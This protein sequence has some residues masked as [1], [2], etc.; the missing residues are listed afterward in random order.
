MRSDGFARLRELTPSGR[1][2]RWLEERCRQLVDT[3]KTPFLAFEVDGSVIDWNEEA[4]RLFGWPREAMA[5]RS[6][7]NTVLPPPFSPADL[8]DIRPP[9]GA[10]DATVRGRRREA[11]A[12]DRQ[13]RLFPVELHVWATRFGV[14][15]TYNAFVH[16]VVPP[17][18]PGKSS[19][20]MGA[21]IESSGEAII[22]TELDGT[23]RTWNHAAEDMFGLS[24]PEAVGQPIVVVVPP[25]SHDAVFCLLAAARD[26]GVV[27]HETSWVAKDGSPVDVAVS[28]SVVRDP[29]VGEPTGFSVIARDVTEE[30]RMSAE[31]NATLAA[32]DEAAAEAREAEA[33][34]RDFL[35]DAAHQLRTPTAGIRACAEALLRHPSFPPEAEGVIAEM[36][37]ETSRAARLIGALL[38]M[39][40]LDQGGAVAPAPCDVAAVCRE[41]V[42]RARSLAPGL[43]IHTHVAGLSDEKP[44]VDADALK[45]ILA[46]LLD[47]A[48]RHAGSRV[49]V[50]VAT[51]GHDLEIRVADDGPGVRAEMVERIFDRF[52]SLDGKGGSGLGLPI[53]RGLARAHGGDL[54]YEDRE[55]VLRMPL[56]AQV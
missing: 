48:R 40:R 51:T 38:Q 21:I 46:N 5:G 49:D 45:E 28:L 32:L 14:S 27:H 39:A 35:A 54:T 19:C 22:G 56:V 24:S 12:R 29:D 34:G 15:H 36:M 10:Q 18:P 16:E 31:L 17:D 47:N 41:E 11:T 20:Q 6:V 9:F 37:A 53:A 44:E 3:A 43:E 55:F 30:R 26:E 52:V 33:R 7:F 25:E 42:Q 2:N 50:T 23:I 8:T 13:G 4:E 1:R